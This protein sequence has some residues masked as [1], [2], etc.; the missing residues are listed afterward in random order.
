MKTKKQI[1]RRIKELKSLQK[2]CFEKRRTWGINGWRQIE[3]LI[4]D[5]VIKEKHRLYQYEI[6]V[7]NWV[8]REEE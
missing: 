4:D 1:R 8:L 3:V 6:D 7:L 5:I 2:D